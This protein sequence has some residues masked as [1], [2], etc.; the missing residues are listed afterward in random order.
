M[1]D[2]FSCGIFDSER[3]FK[4]AKESKE[5]VCRLFE[6]EYVLSGEGTSYVDGKSFAREKN[7]LIVAKPGQ[8]RKSSLHFKCYYM[9]FA[10]DENSRAYDVLTG[11]PT[12]LYLI[13]RDEFT[14]IFQ[15][16]IRYRLA[17]KLPF[18]SEVIQAEM[19][20]LI[21]FISQAAAQCSSHSRSAGISAN[22]LIGNV[23]THIDRNLDKNLSLQA[24]SDATFYSKNYLR[25]VFKQ[26]MGVSPQQYVLSKRIEKAKVLLADQSL[27]LSEVA[28]RCGFSSQSYFNYAFKRQCA[29]SP[30]EAR[31]LLVSHF[32]DSDGA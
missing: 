17:K 31:A 29:T 18:E 25:S 19:T 10:A 1:K 24:L 6:V 23:L 26:T 7:M 27:P 22:R 13:D 32:S 16:V 5:R 30:N 20:K 12:A 2:N 8:K 15:N 3:F 14:A 28:F 9:H 11:C 21:Y 4:N